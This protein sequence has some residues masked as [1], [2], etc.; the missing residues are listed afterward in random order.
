MVDRRLRRR[1]QHRGPGPGGPRPRPDRHHLARHGPAPVRTALDLDAPGQFVVGGHEIR[2]AGFRQTVRELQQR[3]NVFD[4]DVIAGCESQLAAWEA[5]V[6]PGTILDAGPTISKLADLPEAQPGRHRPRRHRAASRPTCAPS[7]RRTGSIRW[8]SSTS[9]PP[10]RPSR[11]SE[12]HRVA[13]PRSTPRSTQAGASC[14]PARSTPGRP[15]TWACRTSTSRRRWARRSRPWRNWPQRGKTVHRRQGRQDGRDADEDGAGADVR[16]AQLA[17][18]Q[19]GRPQHLRQPRR[20]G[21]RR[22]GQQGV[23]DQ[24]QG[25][26]HLAA[27]SA[28]SRKRT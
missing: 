23:E 10:S 2:Q 14:R 7:A 1:G 22:P 18:P 4:A 21:P 6:R 17:D 16:P 9:P 12:V 15:S 3:S 20:P 11:L 19:L 26:G 27:S 24:D 13:R 25:P 28:T 8:S 5:N